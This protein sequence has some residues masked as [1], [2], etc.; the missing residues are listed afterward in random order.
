MEEGAQQPSGALGQ[1]AAHKVERLNAV[2][3]FIDLRD[4][5]ITDELLHSVLA[6]VA[7]PAVDL[8]AGVCRVGSMVRQIGFDDRRHKG[9]EIVR[10]CTPF[11]IG[12]L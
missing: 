5:G 10:G 11:G 9:N 7:V 8:H 12:M 6:D 3:A 2:G 1:L 4:T